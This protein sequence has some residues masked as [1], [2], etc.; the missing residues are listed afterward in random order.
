MGERERGL[1]R[2]DLKIN[3][4]SLSL[5]FKE[6]KIISPDDYHLRTIKIVVILVM[7]LNRFERLVLV[8]VVATTSNRKTNDCLIQR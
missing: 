3:K 7:I 5:G 8:I 2:C 4:L 6:Y 1:F